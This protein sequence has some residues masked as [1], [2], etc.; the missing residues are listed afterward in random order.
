[1][2]NLIMS[3]KYHVA[4]NVALHIVTTMVHNTV[5][6][7]NFRVQYDRTNKKR[8]ARQ[9]DLSTNSFFFLIRNF[10]YRLLF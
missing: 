6:L 1:M 3:K 9:C 5:Q 4:Y 7:F 8:S 10:P 2:Q